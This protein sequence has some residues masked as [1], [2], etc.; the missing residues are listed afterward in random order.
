MSI[1]RRRGFTLIEALV[2][3]VLAAIGVTASVSAFSVLSKAQA[4]SMEKERMIRLADAKFHEL[5]AMGN[6]TNVG[7]T[8]EDQGEQRYTWEATSEPTG[9]EN[10]T[11]LTVSVSMSESTG[12]EGSDTVQGAVYEEPLSSTTT[13]GGTP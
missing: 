2:A 4:R 11:Q 12:R 7:G 5:A 13:T 1:G 9:I 3:V 8:F 10:V 6:L